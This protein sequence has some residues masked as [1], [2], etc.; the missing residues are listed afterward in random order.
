MEIPDGSMVVGVLG[1]IKKTL[2][3]EEQKMVSLAANH[4]IENYKKYKKLNCFMLYFSF[5]ALFCQML[6]SA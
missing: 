5:S 1:K 4:Y 6:S 3:D 2:S